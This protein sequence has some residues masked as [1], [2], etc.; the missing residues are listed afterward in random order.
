[1]CLSVVSEVEP[2]ASRDAR[3]VPG[4]EPPA[5]EAPTR[6]GNKTWFTNPLRGTSFPV[7]RKQLLALGFEE[8]TLPTGRVMFRKAVETKSGTQYHEIVFDRDP[9]HGDHWHKYLT[10][11][12]GR[13]YELN[14]RGY[15]D[16]LDRNNPIPRVHIPSR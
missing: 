4:G 8:R 9:I 10:D 1:M 14:D 5:R 12:T 11:E 16:A 6:Q 7:V 13:T 2:Y 3:T 15:I